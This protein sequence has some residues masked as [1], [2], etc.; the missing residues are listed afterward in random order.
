MRGIVKITYFDQLCS[1]VLNLVLTLREPCCFMAIYVCF[2]CVKFMF[3]EIRILRISFLKDEYVMVNRS[4]T[5][6][7]C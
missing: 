4:L 2:K 6:G 7:K 3:L 1:Q 5:N